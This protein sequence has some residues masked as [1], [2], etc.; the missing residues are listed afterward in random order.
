MFL[1]QV[2]PDQIDLR[3]ITCK[4]KILT[5]AE[6]RTPPTSREADAISDGVDLAE[7]YLMQSTA[8]ANY[9]FSDMASIQYVSRNKSFSNFLLELSMKIS[10]F[11]NLNAVAVSGRVLFLPELFSRQCD[12][13]KFERNST[14][15]FQ[16]QSSVLPAL[17]HIKPGTIIDSNTLKEIRH[18]IPKE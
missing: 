9:I 12:Y 5:E 15:L 8:K 16:E 1:F 14:K 11:P 18:A 3:I 6:R 17:N 13:V 4:S 10:K 7:P 2:L